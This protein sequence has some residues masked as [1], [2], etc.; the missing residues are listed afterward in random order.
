V[1]GTTFTGHPTR[2]TLGNTGTGTIIGRKM[3]E[4]L[5]ALFGKCSWFKSLIAGDDNISICERG[6]KE[7]ITEMLKIHFCF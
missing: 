6:N 3:K 1:T 5:T 4:D 2:T 7:A